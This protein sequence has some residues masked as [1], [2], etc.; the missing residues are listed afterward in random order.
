VPR[1]IKI[2]VTSRPRYELCLPIIRGTLSIYICKQETIQTPQRRKVCGVSLSLLQTKVIKAQRANDHLF[3][4]KFANLAKCLFRTAFKIF[5]RAALCLSLSQSLAIGKLVVGARTISPSVI[6][7]SPAK[8]LQL[9]TGGRAMNN[10][11]TRVCLHKI[12]LPQELCARMRSRRP[13]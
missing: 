4:A 10:T 8:L 13:L 2:H 7:N 11:E 1:R 6:H 3:R 12:R 5:R 9:K